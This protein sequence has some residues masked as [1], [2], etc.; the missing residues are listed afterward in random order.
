MVPGAEGSTFQLEAWRVYDRWLEDDRVLLLAESSAI[1]EFFRAFSRSKRPAPKNWAESYLVAFANV[2]GP[3]V[4]TFDQ[5]LR[6]KS[7]DILW[8]T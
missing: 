4:A 2:A 6:S 3:R 5:A 8:L 1:E 7:A